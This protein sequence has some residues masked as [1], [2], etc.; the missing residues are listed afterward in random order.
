MIFLQ[1]LTALF[2]V[3]MQFHGLLYL[4][5]LYRKRN[6]DLMVVH[7]AR[8]INLSV[9]KCK[10]L[11]FRR[12][13]RKQQGIWVNEG[14]TDQWWQNMIRDISPEEDWK[15]NLRM[16]KPGFDDLCEQLRYSI[17]LLNCERA[18]RRSYSTWIFSST[19]L[20]LGESSSAHE[21]YKVPAVQPR[22]LAVPASR[23]GERDYI[24][25]A[26]L[27]GIPVSRY[28]DLR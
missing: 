7:F 3:L 18:R 8:K 16:T 5:M 4:Y 12:L 19:P 15:K 21:F 28:Q 1:H 17:L 24:I 14:R 13:R 23:A 10:Q 26:Q 27:A 25:S 2:S 6:I 22:P 11:K 20:C 9:K